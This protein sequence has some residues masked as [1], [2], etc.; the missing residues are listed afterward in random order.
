MLKRITLFALAFVG[1]MAMN[2]QST[3]F[4][5]DFN[6]VNAAPVASLP[7]GWS[8][9]DE[10][11]LTP[12][13]TNQV[14]GL[15]DEAWVV[16]NYTGSGKMATSTSDYQGGGQADDW[17]VSP[18]ITLPSGS[19]PNLFF[20]VA[21]YNP[22]LDDDYEV[23]VSTTGNTPSDFTDAPVF[24]ETTITGSGKQQRSV[25]LASYVGEDVYIA[26]R[27]VA[28]TANN[29]YV[30]DILVKDLLTTDLEA[31]S[32][33]ITPFT[34]SGNTDVMG[35]V[36]NNGA[37]AITA[38]DAA[39]SVDG[40]TEHTQTFSG[41]NIET[42]GTYDFTHQDQW[43]A[44]TG[45]H[46]LTVAI[47]NVNGNGDD[48][49]TAN[50]VISKDVTV[51]SGSVQRRPLYEEFTSSYCP[52][53]KDWNSI[54]FDPFFEQLDNSGHSDDYSLI[55]YEYWIP[56]ADPYF[57]NEGLVRG[58]YYGNNADPTMFMDGIEEDYGDAEYLNDIP[59]VLTDQFN[60]ALANDPA[61]FDMDINANLDGTNIN[62]TV[63]TTPFISGSYKL[64]VAVVEKHTT[65]NAATN[66]ETDFY[67]VMMKMLPDADGTTVDFVDGEGDTQTYSVD[68]A[69]ESIMSGY[70]VGQSGPTNGQQM[71]PHVEE[72]NDLQVIAWIQ[73]DSSHKVMQSVNSANELGVQTHKSDNLT[74]YP[75]PANGVL[76][77]ST[78]TPVDVN[79]TN[80]L[81][82]QVFTQQQVGSQDQMNISNLTSGIYF[83]DI[84]GQSATVT[85]KLIVK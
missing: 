39:W 8:L 17:M 5:E 14:A 64:Y 35:T 29:L 66:G 36:A 45:D 10:D 69:D 24:T 71:A 61:F 20:N 80:M 49:D 30:D 73:D 40:G 52:P 42:L 21:I 41:L 72:F 81:G 16:I 51:A 11:G 78:K 26:F 4:S 44:T 18:Q 27:N 28:S 31:I 75:N 74:M 43:D 15:V 82:E 34:A 59:P 84:K 60:D 70:S 38:F 3:L 50:D 77:I 54:T 67:Q 32:I 46:T 56:D 65:G 85:K 47:S 37:D 9:Y 62:V 55:K 83:V 12:V 1:C 76:R 48:G 6:G 63:N 53:C 7:S 22:N 19:N 25:S 68:L 57:T 79:I 33:N 58:N 23:L 13:T 2:A